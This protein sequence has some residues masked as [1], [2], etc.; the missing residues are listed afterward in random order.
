MEVSCVWTYVRIRMYVWM[1]GCMYVCLCLSLKMLVR[2]GQL[3]ASQGNLA[4][5]AAVL[6]WMLGSLYCSFTTWKLTLR[7]ARVP[8]QGI[9]MEI[10]ILATY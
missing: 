10:L 4:R 9:F 1:Y 6:D 3:W 2:H 5:Y 7:L 8:L